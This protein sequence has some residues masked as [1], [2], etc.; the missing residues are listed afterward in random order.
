MKKRYVAPLLI[1]LAVAATPSV[2][3][4]PRN[5]WMFLGF[6]HFLFGFSVTYLAMVREVLKNKDPVLK[7]GER[8]P[9]TMPVLIFSIC[10]VASSVFFIPREAEII[11]SFSVCF[12]LSLLAYGTGAVILFKDLAASYP[13]HPENRTA[14]VAG[15]KV[16]V[17]VNPVNPHKTG[18]TVNASSRFPPLGLGIIA[19]LTPDDYQV[20]L[21]D[22]NVEPFQFIPCDLVG[23]TAFTSSAN[24]AYEIAALYRAAGI[25]VVMGGIHASMVSEEAARHAD[26]VVIGEAEGVWGDLLADFEQGRLK[27]R[28]EGGAAELEGMVEPRRD[29]F[30]SEYLFATVQTSRGCP[31]DCYFCSVSPFNGRK[32]R[33]RPVE[34]VLDELE[35]IPQEF[36]FF[37]DDNILGYGA[38]AEER[39]IRLFKGMAERK[40]NK[41]WFCQASV[42]F[43]DNAEVLRWAAKSGCRM[44]FIGLESAD[45][46]ELAAMGKGLN[47]K[48]D[49]ERA[50]RAIH[51]HQIAV[52]GAFI[53]GSDAE[54]EAS[55]ARKTDYIQ[56][57][58][59]DVVQTTVLTPL[60]G[61]RLFAQYE[62]EG[63]L[64]HTDYPADWDRYNMGE[65]T[66][67]PRHLD[68]ADFAR[69]L[70]K[71]WKRIYSDLSL[72]LKFLRTLFLTRSMTTAFWAYGSNLNYRNTG[73]A[74]SGRAEK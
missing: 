57:A 39:A 54:T 33:Q 4:L 53:F 42:N 51:A 26:A 30:S 18:L 5:G 13:P 40:L 12:L 34:E 59:I 3:F 28:Y 16:L 32:Y 71:C 20:I 49:Y 37:V 44:V 1:F 61:T 15:K 14:K 17:L 67:A 64:V 52:L 2:F 69:T 72:T 24:R 56:K 31:M 66:Y 36:I 60:P 10:T 11:V 68:Q 48:R 63:R 65:L 35:G 41:H 7:I 43:G 22:E 8:T 38:G 58:C 55:M 29:L 19:A 45:P 47:L 50:F 62:R 70:E 73:R 23:I 6:A 27:R 25:P 9:F 21:V 46:E 74:P